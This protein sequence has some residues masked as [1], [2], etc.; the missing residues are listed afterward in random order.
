MGAIGDASS[1]VP[2][3]TWRL[4]RLAQEIRSAL[5]R[6][7]PR[8]IWVIAEVSE[9]ERSLSKPHWFFRLAE[10][11]EASGQR[12]GL[13]A[14]IW[15]GDQRRLFGPG[16]TLRGVVEPKDGIEIRALVEI[17]FWPP[18]GDLRL[19]VRDIDPTWTLGKIALQR[20]ILLEKLTREGVLEIQ[21]R[22]VLAETP[23]IIGL[24]TSVESAAYHDFVNEVRAAGV[25][26]RV[27]AFDARMQGE[28]TVRSV[29]RG[30]AVLATWGVEAI[31]LVRGGGSVADLAW[32]DREE[33]A[34]AIAA[35]RVPVFTGIG[36]EIDTS[37]ADLAA[38][39]R[40]KTPTA[41]A[42]FVVERAREALRAV[43]VARERIA[44]IE[45]E[46]AARARE[47]SDDAADLADRTIARVDVELGLL[48]RAAD[49]FA[50]R[51][52]AVVKDAAVTIDGTSRRIAE[53]VLRATIEA[54]AD[55]RVFESR[56]ASP[57]LA[58]RIDAA[59]GA[60]AA[61]AARLRALEPER[62]IAR[63]YAVLRDESGRIVTDAAAVRA[64]HRLD[65]VVRDGKI[66]TRVLGSE[67]R[68]EPESSDG[69]EEE[70]RPGGNR[71]LEIW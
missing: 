24:I 65:A 17:D 58:A 36:H 47:L 30:L 5:E 29:V 27:V 50:H 33:I 67:S 68:P 71:Q 59:A 43:E 52:P 39:A 16:G 3:D 60:V 41:V 45:D 35:C 6:N 37:I 69:E 54:S 11:D 51:A 38:H 10:T 49:A 64:G 23:L 48:A 13:G 55:V 26:F 19:V 22:L 56:A 1:P 8:R 2:A 42:Q 62:V 70:H 12:Y 34:R 4:S 46:L 53:S 32:F 20:K 44:R 40:F 66:I 63:G 61:A 9:L 57:A 31:A 14:V 7:F 21:K 25:A 15:Q 18:R 28:D